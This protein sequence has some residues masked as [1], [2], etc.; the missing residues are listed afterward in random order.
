MHLKSVSAGS[1]DTCTSSFHKVISCKIYA[2]S[3][4]PH[5]L[6]SPSSSASK[7][8]GK[9]FSFLLRR[10]TFKSLA[11]HL[12]R[13]VNLKGFC[14][15]PWMRHQSSSSALSAMKVGPGSPSRRFRCRYYKPRCPE[16][17]ESG[18]S[19]PGMMGGGKN[20]FDDKQSERIIREA[21]RRSKWLSANAE[22]VTLSAPGIVYG[23]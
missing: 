18:S 17:N 6:H 23:E 20:G 19:M 8:G 16:V 4:D 7:L 3:R 13:T 11:S 1:K 22:H 10:A 12:P 9:C 14:F 21:I 2:L 5:T 15:S